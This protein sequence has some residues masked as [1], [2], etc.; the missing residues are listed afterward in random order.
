MMGAGIGSFLEGLA[1]GVS[2]RRQMEAQALDEERMQI[3]RNE[4]ARAAEKFELFK[5]DHDYEVSKRSRDD[6][7]HQQDRDYTLSERAYQEQQRQLNAPAEQ[8][9]REGVM[10]DTELSKLKLS[11]SQKDVP[12]KDL[13]RKKEMLETENALLTAERTRKDQ[14]LAK[15]SGQEALTRYNETVDKAIGI[16]KAENGADVYVFDGNKYASQDEARNAYRQKNPFFDNY[17]RSP[18]FNTVINNDIANGRLE[19]AKKKLEWTKYPGVRA[20]IETSGRILQAY[21]IGDIDSVNKGLK[22]LSKNPDYLTFG[23]WDP[24]AEIIQKDGKIAGLRVAMKNKKTGKE[25]VREFQTEGDVQNFLSIVTDPMKAYENGD[26]NHKAVIKQ[27][28]EANEKDIE[29]YA[30][31]VKKRAEQDGALREKVWSTL[32]EDYKFKQMSP[33]Q[34]QV[35]FAQKYNIAK[36]GGKSILS[37]GEAATPPGTVKPTTLMPQ[38]AR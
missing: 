36:S 27:Q 29:T 37:A 33:E 16:E 24:N 1:K 31:M 32:M 8:A 21:T 4:D 18:Q 6:T 17:L 7:E 22:E 2:L 34:Q 23:E 35:V 9:K 28:T 3:A 30:D 25:S 14:E 19:E 13:Q 5:K 20:G 12:L 38:T 10:A 15:R 26:A 11:E